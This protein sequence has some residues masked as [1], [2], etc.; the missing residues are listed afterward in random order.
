MTICTKKR[1]NSWQCDDVE[2]DK[3][4]LLSSLRLVENFRIML[5][6]ELKCGLSN[7]R[8][9]RRHDEYDVTSGVTSQPCSSSVDSGL[10]S[11][12]TAQYS[13]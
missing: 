13:T 3:S 9:V 8:T 1:G 4:H 12:V 6:L 11:F 5:S 10:G 7:V 2:K